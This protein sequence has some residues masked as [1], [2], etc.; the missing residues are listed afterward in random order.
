[1]RKIGLHSTE[2]TWKRGR[3]GQESS[4]QRDGARMWK[5]L[6]EGRFFILGESRR[7]L[8][9]S[10]VAPRSQMKCKWCLEGEG[11]WIKAD[12]PGE[13]HCRYLDMKS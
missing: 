6:T 11:Q 8:S 13:S 3:R 12:G 2:R 9:N 1:M 5:A 7:L 4:Q 10:Y